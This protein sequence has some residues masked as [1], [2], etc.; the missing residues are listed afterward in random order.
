MAPRSVEPPST[1]VERTAAPAD[2]PAPADRTV[3]PGSRRRGSAGGPFPHAALQHLGDSRVEVAHIAANLGFVVRTWLGMGVLAIGANV[4]ASVVVA[5]MI[6]AVN[7]DLTAHQRLVTERTSVA[8]ISAA[9]VVAAILGSLAQRRTL[10]W[11]LRGEVPTC[12]E[13]RRAVSMPRDVALMT[14]LLWGFGAVLIPAVELLSGGT[15]RAAVGIFSGLVVT[16]L[17]AAGVTYLLIERAARPVRRLALEAWPPRE[18]PLFDLRWR[19]M[20]VW[21][22]T[23]GT[24]IIGLLMVLTVPDA[25]R[26]VVIS[27]AV[28]AAVAA[29]A[30]GVLATFMVARSIGAPLVEL[31]TALDRVGDGDLDVSVPVTDSGEIGVVQNGVNEMVEGL[32]ERDRISDLFGRHVG[33]A[34]AQEALRSGV[35]LSGE[36][37]EVVALFVDITGSTALAG[38]SDPVEFVA[39]LN[40]F[41]QIVVDEVE[42]NGGL[43][44]KFEGDAALAVF[45]APIAMDDPA[46]PALRVARHIRDRVAATGEV[47]VGVGVSFG[48]VVAGQVGARSR[49]E[50]TVIGDAVNE[51]SRLTDLAKTTPHHLLASGPTIARAS[52]DEQAHWTRY[53]ESLLRGRSK[54]TDLWT[55]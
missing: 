20:L 54:S 3:E 48:P 33:M 38:A 25:P 11:L 35:T 53:G 7:K 40:R 15:D 50:F 27:T 17:V 19:L 6:L 44:N 2:R 43:I 24:P 5:G 9:I 14:T 8:Y 21:G 23:S 22:C 18:A 36:V 29:L 28:S 46:T 55:A 42:S 26:T 37:R 30:V 16:G 10:R 49:L 4:L 12:G 34:V 31:V 41:F 52:A 45:G 1:T 32:R 39:M 47:Q 13:A 51:A